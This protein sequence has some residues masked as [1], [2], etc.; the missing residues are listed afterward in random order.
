MHA[1]NDSLPDFFRLLY[2][3]CLSALHV[4]HCIHIAIKNHGT[5]SGPNV[6]RRRVGSLLCLSGM[7]NEIVYPSP[8]VSGTSNEIASRYI[9][10][11]RVCE[12]GTI[13]HARLQH[14]HETIQC[15][16]SY[17][18]MSLLSGRIAV[19]R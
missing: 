12:I 7:H 4:S 3:F 17:D 14:V 11:M 10:C 2:V 13:M 15:W 5:H 18:F 16:V 1:N 9:H 19:K 8:L 6:L